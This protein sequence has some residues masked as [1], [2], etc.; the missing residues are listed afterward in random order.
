MGPSDHAPAGASEFANHVAAQM[1]GFAHATDIAEEAIARDLEEDTSD[2]EPEDEDGDDESSSGSSTIRQ[3]SMINSY[4]RPS[5]V[6]P[7]MR[8]LAI[9]STSAPQGHSFLSTSAKKHNYLSKK[10]REAV[11][12][13]ERSLLR[14]NNLLLPKHPRSGS[15]GPASR[16]GPRT[17]FS[18]L[19]K[20]RSSPDEESGDLD[21]A[22]EA[23]ALLSGGDGG[24]PER[25]YGGFDTPKTINKKWNEAV[26]AGKIN[27]SWKR[28]TKVLAKSSAPMVLTFLL[29]YSLPVASI[30]T[31]GHIG[32][33]ELGAVSLASMTAS[34]TG[35]AVYQGLATSLDTLCAQAY[36][37]GRP[38]LVGLQLQRMLAF[39]MLITIP[40]AIIWAL[41]EQILSLIVPEPE[42]A[43]LA[44]LYL[45]VLIFGAP[46]YAAFESGKRYVQAQG[47]FS[48][49][50]Y[51]LL[52]CAPL[53]AFLNW[54]FVWHLGWGFVGAPIAVSITENLL[55]ILLFL[56]VRFIDGYQ[57]WGGFD[58]RAL[59]NWTPMIKLALP[60]LIMVL[61]EFLAFEVLTLSSSWLGATDL[62][63]QSVLGS[64]T[65]L[66]FQ[67][68][69][70]MSVAA[71]T[72]IANL[73]GATLA[74]PAKTAAKV[75]VVAA[76]FVGFFNLLLLSVFR[77]Q[78]ASLFTPDQ[79]VIDLV[80]RLLPIC[81]TFQVF[82]ALAAN[83]NGILRGLGRQEIGGYVGLFAYYLVG[84][85]I[86][87]GTGF[88]LGWGLYGLWVGPAVAL[89]VVA[90]I[91][92]VFI[93]RT[94]WERA[95][96]QAKIRNAAN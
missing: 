93:Y 52:L 24:D 2:S 40:I 39:L 79:D 95:V 17:S 7:G 42:T 30:F 74:V 19:R 56:Y 4:R 68:P 23:D 48:V 12:D 59:K 94:S 10:E 11:R 76:V 88:G 61:A 15:V 86:S 31:V 87:F 57:C 77:H 33:T 67:I 1:E 18:I 29:Q 73:I 21:G 28:E 96:E 37:S 89:G 91:E 45:R 41:G 6:N 82:D 69:F 66:T 3:Y 13:D 32:K 47:L 44:G 16:I 14:D 34:I 84:M 92:S 83:C 55:P 38:H 27:T 70:P 72:R 85:P 5:Y 80:A 71:S 81:A 60:G 75:A 62:A 25:P 64:V 9:T 22:S 54:L 43:R 46:G 51:I 36:G 63:A 8:G 58:R 26:A 50:M 20:V 35:Y 53:N 90:A 49:N 65:G 78:I